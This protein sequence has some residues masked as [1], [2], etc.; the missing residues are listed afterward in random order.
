M[1]ILI[2]LIKRSSVSLGRSLGYASGSSNFWISQ[3][4]V[5]NAR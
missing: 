3:S 2:R 4:A 5:P 1:F